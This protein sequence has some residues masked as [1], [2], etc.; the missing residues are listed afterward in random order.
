[1]I[2]SRNVAVIA[3]ALLAVGFFSAGRFWMHET[4]GSTPQFA[5]GAVLSE[6]D[7]FD[8]AG[9]EISMNTDNRQTFI[10]HMSDEVRARIGEIIAPSA[11]VADHTKV[12]EDR[13]ELK[14]EDK[15]EDASE[16]P[17]LRWCDATVLESQF[18]ASW[19]STGV[20]VEN[21]E[22]ALVV[23]LT[24]EPT[25]VGT[26]TVTAPPRP[27]MQFAV[28][29]PKR[30]E[31]ACL[32]HG[33]VGVTPEG[34]LIHTND[35]VLY[36]DRG[37]NELIGYAFDGNPIYGPTTEAADSCGGV[38][39]GVYRYHVST[40]RDFIIGCFVSEPQQTLWVG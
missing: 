33:F 10:E 11:Q 31:P 26:T 23:L 30:T 25:T 7:R 15:S 2:W 38:D 35:V 24:P 16:I 40:E 1:M 13:H 5:A 4:A 29:P 19:P 32:T 17:E 6:G 28:N 9:A 34:R 27:L 8:I 36:Q 3:L 18:V 12:D 39:T 14:T 20:S 37:S 22:G 21:R